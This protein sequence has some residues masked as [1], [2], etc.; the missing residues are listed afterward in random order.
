MDVALAIE[1][2]VGLGVK[3]FGSTTD[4]TEE[5]YNKLQWNDERPKPLWAELIAKWDEIKD[6]PA[7]KDE[8][9]FVQE[10]MDDHESRI[11]AI[12]DHLN[13]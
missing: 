8:D 6:I 1:A 7:P 2:L 4:N 12:E 11:K 10:K 5:Q 3:Y 9:E 13:L